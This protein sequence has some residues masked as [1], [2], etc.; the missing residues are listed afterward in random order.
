MK[1]KAYLRATKAQ[2]DQVLAW[3]ASLI[4]PRGVD[5]TKS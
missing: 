2:P 5:K 4:L 3:Q 1:S